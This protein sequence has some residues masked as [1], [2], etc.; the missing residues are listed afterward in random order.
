MMLSYA[1]NH[2]ASAIAL[3]VPIPAALG[4]ADNWP[5]VDPDFVIHAVSNV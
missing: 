3:A 5:T 2:K 1:I 4:P